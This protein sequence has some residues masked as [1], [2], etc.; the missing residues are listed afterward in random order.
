M[1]QRLKVRKQP[2]VQNWRGR[3]MRWRHV[4]DDDSQRQAVKINDFLYIGQLMLTVTVCPQCKA[5]YRSGGMECHKTMSRLDMEWSMRLILTNKVST[6]N[7]ETMSAM[8][9][10][11]DH[12]DTGRQGTVKQRNVKASGS[13][14]DPVSGGL[15]REGARDLNGYVGRA[16][17]TVEKSRMQSNA[18]NANS[19]RIHS[20]SER[21]D[22]STAIISEAPRMKRSPASFVP[23]IT[24]NAKIT[25]N[26]MVKCSWKHSTQ[27][28]R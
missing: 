18:T 3:L 21:L 20:S 24:S 2:K 13:L 27:A 10:L 12:R 14:E 22:S 1:E 16:I 7:A 17:R 4:S 25:R 19:N 5:V 15:L 28:V 8:E 6:G 26:V 11:W 9:L 23:R